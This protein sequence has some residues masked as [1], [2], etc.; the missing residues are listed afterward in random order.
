MRSG[1]QDSKGLDLADLTLVKKTPDRYLIKLKIHYRVDKISTLDPILNQL[2]PAQTFT[3]YFPNI[4]FNIVFAS[5]PVSEVAGLT[6]S[7]V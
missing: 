7:E 4:N 3:Q 5:M 6:F 1:F 2:N